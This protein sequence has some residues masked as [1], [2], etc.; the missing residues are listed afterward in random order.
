MPAFRREAR[1]IRR[2]HS[3]T[4]CPKIPEKDEEAV[5]I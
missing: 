1:R 5:K 2:V 4:D 3:N